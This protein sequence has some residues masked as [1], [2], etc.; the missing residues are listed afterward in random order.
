MFVVIQEWLILSSKGSIIIK[1]ENCLSTMRGKCYLKLLKG[2]TKQHIKI[3]ITSTYL[4]LIMA[5]V[6]L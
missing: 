5:P 6:K 4:C 3:K 2:V 1:V